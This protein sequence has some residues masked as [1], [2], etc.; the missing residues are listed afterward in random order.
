MADYDSGNI[1]AKILRGEIP[2]HRVYED[3]AVIAF[4]DVMPQG[5][6]HTLVVPKA[7]SRNLLDADA[8]TLGPLFTIV[9]KLA[10]AVKKAFGADGV[11]ILQFNEPASGQTVYHLHVHVI[12]RFEG[13]PLKPHSGQMEQPEVL[14]ENASKIRAALAD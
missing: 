9:Q 2:S 13:I 12:P 5:A 4:M 8:A 1:F 14:A 6:G 11:T 10:R 7:P 3:D